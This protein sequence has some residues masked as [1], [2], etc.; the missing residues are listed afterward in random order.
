LRGT[1]KDDPSKRAWKKLNPKA[2]EEYVKYNPDLLLSDYAKHFGASIP[3]LEKNPCSFL[4]SRYLQYGA[5]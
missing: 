1:L 5:F 3:G 4:F 2:L